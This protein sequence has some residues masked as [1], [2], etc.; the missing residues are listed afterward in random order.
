MLRR[1]SRKAVRER[2]RDRGRKKQR[3]A[4]G[5]P[6][7]ET[8]GWRGEN[9]PGRERRDRKRERGEKRGRKGKQMESAEAEKEGDCVKRREKSRGGM[10][11]EAS[12]NSPWA[13]A[14]GGG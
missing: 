1:R 6:D 3:L 13:V 2:K 4:G 8:G 9:D 5:N 11:R 12:G 14:L 7:R 10:R